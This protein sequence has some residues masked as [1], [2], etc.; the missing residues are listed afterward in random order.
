[1]HEQT[2]PA[3]LRIA[4]H[5]SFAA[6][7]PRSKASTPNPCWLKRGAVIDALEYLGNPLADAAKEKLKGSGIAEVQKILDPLCRV[8]ININPESRVKS[9]TQAPATRTHGNKAG[10]NSHQ[11][12]QRSGRN[13]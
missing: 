7:C 8:G 5:I 13:R 1:V 11:D 9:R 4:W 10:A 6:E 12:S 3:R 2:H